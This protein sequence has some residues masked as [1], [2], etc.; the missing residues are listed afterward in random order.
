[1]PFLGAS[2]SSRAM[3][4]AIGSYMRAPSS[5]LRRG[6]L[7]HQLAQARQRLL[8]VVLRRG[9]QL[10]V[11]L[12]HRAVPGPLRARVGDLE[13]LVGGLR[14]APGQVVGERAVLARRLPLP[15]E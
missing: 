11:H 6:R 9:T 4:R 2:T 1:M 13:Q 10:L 15:V 3:A 14:A 8:D 5:T 7:L 12:L